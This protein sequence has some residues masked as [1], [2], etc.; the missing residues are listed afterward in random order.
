MTQDEL[1]AAAGMPV[2]SLRRYL[3][4]QR[5]INVAV[6]SAICQ[7]L[8]L[9]PQWVVAQAEERRA[10]QRVDVGFVDKASGSGGFLVDAQTRFGEQPDMSDPAAVE[11]WLASDDERVVVVADLD[12]K[13]PARTQKSAARKTGRRGS[14]AQPGE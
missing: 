7:A 2:V 5:D 13:A 12:P 8:E 10:K 4:G 14:T 3:N 11:K 6:L 9:D 1:A